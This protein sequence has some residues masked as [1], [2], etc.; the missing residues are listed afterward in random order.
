VPQ[1]KEAG[2]DSI[3]KRLDKFIDKIDG[4]GEKLEKRLEQL[5]QLDGMEDRII[6]QLDPCCPERRTANNQAR[7]S[8]SRRA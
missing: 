2:L 6:A 5:Y 7:H 8:A 3:L 1:V 4:M